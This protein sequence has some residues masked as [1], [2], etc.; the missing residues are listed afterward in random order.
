[1]SLFNVPDDHPSH[2]RFLKVCFV[3]RAEPKADQEHIRNYGGIVC[4]SCRAFFRRAH[5]VLHIA[6][7]Q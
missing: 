6:V 7:V 2:E 1:M 4:F 5:Q 3:C